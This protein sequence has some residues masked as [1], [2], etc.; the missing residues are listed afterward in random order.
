MAFPALSSKAMEETAQALAQSTNMAE[1]ARILGIATPTL[2]N[3]VD[4]MNRQGFKWSFMEPPPKDVEQE[5]GARRDVDFWRRIANERQKELAEV[6]AQLREVSGLLGRPVQPPEWVMPV[7]GPNRSVA[8]GLLQISDIHMGEVIRPE[9]V[10]GLNEFHPEIARRRLRRLFASVTEIL[11]RWSSDCQVKGVVVAVNGDLISGD[12]HEELARTNALSSME[13]AYAVADELAAGLEMLQAAFGDV[14]AVFTPGNHGRTTERTHAKRTVTLSYDMLVGEMVRRHFAG[15]E[16]VVVHLSTGPEAVYPIL[17]WTVHQSHGDSLGT[18]GGK[19][20]SGP[21]LP[22]VRGTRNV[23]LQAYRVRQHYDI[24]L[25][26]HYHVSGNPGGGKLANGSV[27]GFSEYANRIRAGY[28]PPQQWLAL[29][30]QKWGIRER[31]E[32]R[33][34]DPEPPERPRVRVPAGISNAGA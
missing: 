33:L 20:F 10:G 4:S 11:P 27:V 9:E 19:G 2:R 34:E 13:Q 17:G 22:I 12:I 7:P 23:E 14:F 30:H 28:E 21:M 8:I 29:V 1:A 6:T 3:R 31:A 24:V 15:K 25:T 32:I 26:A 16:G 18:G 5:R